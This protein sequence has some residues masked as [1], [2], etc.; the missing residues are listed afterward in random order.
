MKEEK[1]QDC[2][3]TINNFRGYKYIGI[4]YDGYM[5]IGIYN[6]IYVHASRTRSKS[7]VLK[8]ILNTLLIEKIICYT[9]LKI[10]LL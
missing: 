6:N 3:K 7:E 8:L 5:D 1:N 9:P 10:H 4:Y 2:T